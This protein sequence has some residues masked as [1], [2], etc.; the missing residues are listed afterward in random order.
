MHIYILYCY[1]VILSLL[2]RFSSCYLPLKQTEISKN[3]PSK[4]YQ[5]ALSRLKVGFSGLKHLSNTQII[6]L[7][8]PIALYQIK[9][10][11]IIGEEQY[12][13]INSVKS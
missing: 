11:G 9:T 2:Q 6:P 3:S 4:C 5:I 12:Q 7:Q 10:N 1:I 8:I 13:I